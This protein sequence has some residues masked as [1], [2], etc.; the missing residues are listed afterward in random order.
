MK[1]SAQ[2]TKTQCTQH[3]ETQ[4]DDFQRFDAQ[5]DNIEPNEIQLNDTQYCNK[6]TTLSITTLNIMLHDAERSYDERLVFIVMLTVNML[7][8]YSKM[9]TSLRHNFLNILYQ[10]K[11]FI[12][13]FQNHP[14]DKVLML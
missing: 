11:N 12:I 13:T 7:S 5:N 10:N 2:L 6:N 8:S 9:Q 1:V 4:H 3:N 14:D